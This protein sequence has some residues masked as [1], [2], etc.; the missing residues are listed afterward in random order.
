MRWTALS[1][2]CESMEKPCPKGSTSAKGRSQDSEPRAD[3]HGA[4]VTIERC[5]KLS[6]QCERSARCLRI[7]SYAQHRNKGAT[8]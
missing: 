3:F 6:R 8:T 2:C 1:A 7:G 5:H 4:A